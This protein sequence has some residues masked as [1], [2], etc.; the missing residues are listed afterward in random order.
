M[1][2]QL[3]NQGGQ[4]WTP[5]QGRYGVKAEPDEQGS[6]GKV[7]GPNGEVLVKKMKKEPALRGLNTKK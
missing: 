5:E 2:K 1:E 4:G 3:L 7:H 6:K